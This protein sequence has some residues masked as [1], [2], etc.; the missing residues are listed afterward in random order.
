MGV[1][2]MMFAVRAKRCVWLD[3]WYNLGSPPR[4]ERMSGDWW[5]G[6]LAALDV[7]ARLVDYDEQT[8]CPSFAK[9]TADGN[10]KTAREFIRRHGA[11]DVYFIVT[12]GVDPTCHEVAARDGYVPEEH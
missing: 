9:D 12:D 1:D 6:Y 2:C 3:R 7:A 5:M 11:D 8:G 4:D 10:R